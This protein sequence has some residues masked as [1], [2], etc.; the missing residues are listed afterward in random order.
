[1]VTRPEKTPAAAPSSPAPDST[2]KPL[3]LRPPMTTSSSDPNSLAAP[4]RTVACMLHLPVCA[5]LHGWQH[6]SYAPRMKGGNVTTHRAVRRE[7]Q[8]AGPQTHVL[9][10]N[11]HQ[12]LEATILDRLRRVPDYLWVVELDALRP[13][14]STSARAGSLSRQGTRTSH[15]CRRECPQ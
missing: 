4:C 13:E 14:T 5:V 15:G 2:T 8:F 12:V 10:Q 3:S 1:M 6:L 7:D 11:V 9:P